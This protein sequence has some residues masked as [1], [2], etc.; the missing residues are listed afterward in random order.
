Q[1]ASAWQELPPGIA[2]IWANEVLDALPFHRVRREGDRLVELW[3]TCRP[4]G[5]D[6]FH[7]EPG[8]LSTSE[9]ADYFE[10]L[11][12]QPAEGI[13]VEVNLEASAWLRAA[14][15]AM[16]RGIILLLDYGASAGALYADPASAGTLRTYRRHMLG[17]DPFVHIGEQDLTADVDFTTL[18]HVAE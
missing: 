17:V 12:I 4:D 10:R 5:A 3:V 15:G 7:E 9:I 18:L 11:G 8:P 14:A 13:P 6:G 2:V 1:W 16:S